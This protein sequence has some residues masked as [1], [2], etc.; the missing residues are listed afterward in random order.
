MEEWRRIS[1]FPNGQIIRLIQ[2]P[3]LPCSINP[4]EN[5]FMW[6]TGGKKASVT[7]ITYTLS[8]SLSIFKQINFFSFGVLHFM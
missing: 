5:G 6:W 8:L 1:S 3:K 7:L 2:N 4:K